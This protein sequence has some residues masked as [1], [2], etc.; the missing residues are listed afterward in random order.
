MN[1]ERLIKYIESPFIT[2]L[3]IGIIVGV[4]TH[5]ILQYLWYRWKRYKSD[6]KWRT[7]R[8]P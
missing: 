7:T 6:Q 3:I 1:I 8:L 5:F 2:G 4:I